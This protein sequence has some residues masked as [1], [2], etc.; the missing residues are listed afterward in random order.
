MTE[1]DIRPLGACPKCGS[2][3]FRMWGDGWD[4]DRAICPDRDCDYDKE[5]DTMTGTDPD[6]SVWQWE[7][8]EER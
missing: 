6:G 8:E 4:W 5:L 3:L 2:Q 1:A 7:K